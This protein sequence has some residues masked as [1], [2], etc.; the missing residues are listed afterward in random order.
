MAIV[1]AER[2]CLGCAL[3]VLACPEDAMTLPRSFIVEI[4]KDKCTECR[5]CIDFC[6]V[7]A[8][9]EV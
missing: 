1:V 3:C 2:E 7:D 5:D 4:N 9:K 6:P 8:L